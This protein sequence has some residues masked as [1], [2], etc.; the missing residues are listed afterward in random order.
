[1]FEVALKMR[2]IN[3]ADLN[4]DFFDVQVRGF[5]QLARLFQ[6][7]VIGI[8]Y[9]AD[10]DFFFEKMPETRN[11]YIDRCRQIT[12][13]QLLGDVGFDLFE[14]FLYSV[15]H[16]PVAEESERAAKIAKAQTVCSLFKR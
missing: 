16:P 7:Q 3:R 9:N 10:P 12:D 4:S 8:F 14:Y 11:G 15:I 5:Q 13:N 1:M 2:F 6:P